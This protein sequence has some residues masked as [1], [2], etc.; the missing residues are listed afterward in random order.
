M[1]RKATT[2]ADPSVTAPGV[3][4]APVPEPGTVPGEDV[5][6]GIRDYA[7]QGPFDGDGL[8]G[9]FGI[10][11]CTFKD[12]PNRMVDVVHR[13]LVQFGRPMAEPWAPTC[14]R[15]DVMLPPHAPDACHDPQGLARLIDAQRMPDQQ[16]LAILITLRFEHH[17]LLHRGW[18]LV[19]GFALQRLAIDRDTPVVAAM[20]VPQVAGRRHKPHVHLIASA[21]RILGSNCADFVTDLL[22]TDAK[23]NAARLWADWR[24]AHD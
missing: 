22:G 9:S 7:S 6:T 24:A 11:P 17:A 19:R 20:H 18:E 2:A 13:R 10:I 4:I 5:R 1:V 14:T 12:R 16:D 21:R 8:D 15:F 23:A 3:M